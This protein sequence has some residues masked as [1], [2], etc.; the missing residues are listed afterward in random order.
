MFILQNAF[1]EVSLK[2]LNL[3]ISRLSVQGCWRTCIDPAGLGPSTG[4]QHKEKKNKGR[5]SVLAML[6][7]GKQLYSFDNLKKKRFF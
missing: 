3:F 5:I 4:D 1:Q 6:F 7:E 2:L